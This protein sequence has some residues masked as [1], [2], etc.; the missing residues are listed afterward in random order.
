[1]CQ[2]DLNNS[3]NAVKMEEKNSLKLEENRG[4]NTPRYWRAAAQL[5]EA[6]YVLPVLLA[7]KKVY[8]H[9]QGPITRT[10]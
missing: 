5:G 7:D 10:S 6:E 2:R 4:K 3:F 1:M 8:L 9:H